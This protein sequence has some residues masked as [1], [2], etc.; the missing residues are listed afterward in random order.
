VSTE[1]DLVLILV[2]ISSFEV[3]GPGPDIWISGSLV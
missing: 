2:L 1:G 3:L